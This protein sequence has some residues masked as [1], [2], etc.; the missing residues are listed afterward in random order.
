MVSEVP[1]CLGKRSGYRVVIGGGIN[2]FG[3]TI[4]QG[5]EALGM[6]VRGTA[7]EKVVV[8]THPRI[9]RLYGEYALSS[10]RRSGF[11]TF[12]YQFPEGEQNKTL[13]QVG[14]I[15][16][17]LIENRF[18]RSSTLVALGGGVV[19]D[20]TGFAAATFLRG[21]SY[22]Q[23][24]T[25]VVAQ[26]DA[27][28][29]GKTGVDHPSG[30]NLI[31]AFHQPSLVFV[32][33]ST[34]LTLPKREFVAGLAEVVKY[35]VIYDPAFF[36]FIEKH[37]DLILKRDEEKLLYCIKRSVEIKARVVSVDE[38]ESG[39]RKILNFGHTF[40]H[41][42]ETLTGYRTYKHGEAVSIGMV[43]AARAAYHM[44][45]TKVDV[46]LRLKVLLGRLGLPTDFPKLC[47]VDIMRALALDKKVISG[48]IYFVLPERIGK[49]SV[50][51]I[52]QKQLVS[53]LSDIGLN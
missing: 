44:G 12:L 50:A 30:K 38:K 45:I 25:T 15:Y 48:E 8:I 24:P 28:I 29:G 27:A 21:I 31:G 23:C 35:G 49:V 42:V 37:V 3:D 18:E 13:E 22:I 51:P 6:K 52:G 26:V 47:S 41:A 43:A 11:D 2:A 40:G 9:G 7:S 16:D 33:P 19:G 10:L 20:M 14:R 53:I 46:V 1:V 36:S 17:F 32:D 5:R 39:L 34:L 4:I